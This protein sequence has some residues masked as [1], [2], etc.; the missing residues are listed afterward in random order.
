M[1]FNG[2]SVYDIKD[3]E[4]VRLVEDHISERQYLEYK[5]TVKY[6]DPEEKRE[7]LRDI[8]SLANGGGGYII[9]G[10]RDDGKG[11]ALRFEP[12]LVGDTGAI[13]KS[14]RNLCNEHISERILNL[15]ID[16]RI[17]KGAPVVLIR[18][19]ESLR[20]PHMVKYQNRTDFFTRYQD[21]KRE[22]TIGE[23]KEGFN[24]DMVSLR[25]TGIETNLGRIIRN[26]S[27]E[28][29]QQI[30][31]YKLEEDIVPQF[32]TIENVDILLA[33][34]YRR[35]AEGVAE[36]PCFRIAAT[37]KSPCHNLLDVDTGDLRDLL[38]NP[39]GSRPN[40]WSMANPIL[41]IE[42]FAEGLRM[43]EIE[44]RYL[45]LLNNC[46]MEYWVPLDG[47]FC[48]TQSREEFKI[49]PKIYPY[50]LVEYTTSFL[51]LYREIVGLANIEDDI[52]ITINLNN[53]KGYL[54]RPGDHESL[55]FH[56][57]ITTDKLFENKHLH[58]P[59]IGV[60]YDFRSDY[61]SY[62][63]LKIVYS[64]F[65]LTEADIPYYDREKE[66]FIFP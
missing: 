26:Q 49:S 62:R 61:E 9:I 36:M 47:S 56:A 42:R 31:D 10:I 12:E 1:I 27:L 39:P 38:R 17:I 35:F 37:P 43:G 6:K 59:A 57:P 2:K 65:G 30:V 66:E 55:G 5:V 40:G 15:E 7:T 64:A 16:T 25:L 52:Y 58:P 54:L 13:A 41:P 18:V 46:H 19:P 4:I 11:K 29:G 34:S 8:A 45:E 14:I 48:H 51:R 20:V 32:T 50:A 53:I 22:M 24:K 63:L 60:K 28:R 44:Y 3:S 23:I 21:G 33:N